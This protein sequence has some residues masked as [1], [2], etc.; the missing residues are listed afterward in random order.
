[1]SLTDNHYRTLLLIAGVALFF[2]F[3]GAAPLF[4]WDEVNFAESAREMIVTGNYAR[5][6]INFQPFWEKPPLFFWM[7]VLSMKVF[8]INEYAAR[9]PNACFGLITILSLFEMGK[10]LRN[11]RFGFLWAICM[12]GSFLPFVYFKSGI[13]DPVFN[14]FIFT[15]IWF[16]ALTVKHY[17]NKLAARYSM[18]GGLFIGLA[19]LTKGPVALV[20]GGLTALIFW[21]MSRF[22]PIVSFKNG[23]LY[24]GI[25]LVVSAIWFGPETYLN[26]PWFLKEFIDYQIRLFSTQDAGHGQPF[27]YHFVVVLLGCFPM[28][29]WALK[30]LFRHSETKLANPDFERWM[31]ILLWVVLILFSIVKTKIVHYSSMAYLPL[32]LIAALSLEEWLLKKQSWTIIQ[33]VGVFTVGMIPGLAIVLIPIVGQHLE[34]LIPFIKDPFAAKNLEAQ[35]AWSS[36]DLI[37]G[38]IWLTGILCTCIFLRKGFRIQ[39]IVTSFGATLLAGSIFLMS[40]PARIAEYTQQAAVEFYKTLQGKDVYVETLH[41]KSYAQYF[42]SR[43][44]QFSK[45]EAMHSK[46]K[47]GNYD[48]DVL[49]KWYLS[50]DIDKPAYFVVKSIHLD[51]YKNNS[52]LEVIGEKNGFTFLKRAITKTN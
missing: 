14:Y 19:V 33:I 52:E 18:L 43:K 2:P 13:I 48:I 31:K 29:V 5:V 21:G 10:R 30:G 49:R 32:S 46:D 4:D 37:P 23:L 28:S 47:T 15:S 44:Q 3:L 20:L 24:T 27:Y 51:E 42:Y 41:F 22:K 50:G 1:M 35:V 7:Q 36:V 40:F 25:A 38:F 9:F 39:A 8:G 16:I 11:A 12:M 26:G 17:G 45:Q 34:Q 6:Q